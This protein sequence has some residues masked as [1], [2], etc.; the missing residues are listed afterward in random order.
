MVGKLTLT[1]PPSAQPSSATRSSAT[2]MPA[3]VQDAHF[4][5]ARTSLRQAINRFSQQLRQTQ[6]SPRGIDLQASIKT[7]LDQ[8]SGALD[9]LNE[10]TVRIA[11]FGL[12]SRG[13]SAVINALI[14]QKLLQTG[15]LHGVTQYPRSVYWSPNL[16]A[17]SLRIEL[18]DTPGLDEVGGQLRSNIARDIAEQADLIL[19]VISGDISRTEYQALADLQ[20]AHKPILIVFNKIDLY[21]NQD[22]QAI[23]R[24]LKSLFAQ[25]RTSDRTQPWFEPDDIVLV[26]AEPAPIEVQVEYADGRVEYEWES[27]PPDIAPLQQK[28]LT[29]LQQEGKSLLAINA[30]RQARETE[31][32]LAHNSVQIHKAEAENLIWQYAKWKGVAIALNPIALLDLLGGAA[33]DLIM[34]RSLAKLYGLPMTRYEAGKL[35]N[36]ILLS[37]GGLLL[38]EVGG[39]LLLGVG[40]SAAAATSLFDSASGLMAY[41]TAAIAQ[42]SLAGYGSYRVGKAAQIYLEQGCT[43]GPQG[44]N[45][46]IQDILEQSD[47]EAIINRLHREL[48]TTMPNS[49]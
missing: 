40:K 37:S 26:S 15:P 12:V 38:G 41:S 5:R 13:K 22:Q 10:A 45:T 35:L 49:R 42:A 17:S 4:Q 36:T 46:I 18:T 43:W 7:G 44:A 30:L 8:L 34:I 39:G 20:L 2:L 28:L 29:L 23:Y 11:V 1:Q 27:P 24:R 6:R 19:F 9:K 21:P 32:A 25:N 14:G 47:S 48:E 3:D 31:K 33:T 16:P